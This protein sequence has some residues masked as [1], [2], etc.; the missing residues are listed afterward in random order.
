MNPERIRV[1]SDGQDTAPKIDIAVG[2]TL[3]NATGVL[4]YVSRN[5][6]F[7]P[8]PTGPV[9]NPGPSAATPV[10]APTASE[11]T[12][13]G[14]NLQRFYDDLDDSSAGDAILTSAAFANRLNKASLGIRNVLQTPDLLAVV[15]MENLTVLGQLASKVNSDAVAAGQPN[16]NYT[17]LLV[18]GN[19]SGGIDVGFL[20]KTPK[21]TVVD[22]IQF[23]KTET[24]IPPGTTTPAL[25]NDRPPLRLRVNVTAPGS[26]AA[27]PVTVFVVHHRSLTSIND[28]TDGPRVRAKRRAQAEYLANLVQA[29]QAAN[30]SQPTL[31][32]G[33]FN[34]FEVNDGYVDVMGISRGN[35]APANETVLAGTDLVNPDFANLIEAHP[36]TD[37]FTYLF[38]GNAQV[39]DHVLVNAPAHARFSGFAIAHINT[40]FPE[41]VRN[42]PNR[43]ERLSDH[44][45]PVV[46]LT[47][48]SVTD[49]STVVRAL[50]LGTTFSSATGQYTATV[51]VFNSGTAAVNAPIHLQVEGLPQGVQL[52]N[53]TGLNG[54]FPYLTV[55]SQGSLAP[56]AGVTVQ[57][58]YS[59]ATA[60]PRPV[61]RATRGSY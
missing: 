22:A 24:Y 13:A 34:A 44:D 20:I 25:L 21:V 60:I 29:Y 57:L 5:F 19:D 43:A 4:S 59:G 9:V 53:R 36:A 3:A 46:Y 1:D 10:P 49:I 17:P 48:P 2:G 41:I 42:D 27:L 33:D 32:L 23:G 51:R 14:Y 26:V 40:P 52:V 39:L 6:T 8:D 37:R 31:V 15:E 56:G 11:F 55:L 30:P 61:L 58:R 35:P 12:V 50:V 18:E 47:L 7:Y 28:A 38:G 45:A 16:P 54:N